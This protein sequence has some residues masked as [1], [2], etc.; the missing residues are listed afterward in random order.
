MRYNIAV[1]HKVS[2][3]H[4]FSK[5]SESESSYSYASNSKE[6][7]EQELFGA[8][9]GINLPYQDEPLVSYPENSDVEEADGAMAEH[10]D[11]DRAEDED[12]IRP[13][14][15][16]KRFEGNIPLLLLSFIY[17]LLDSKI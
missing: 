9:G 8:I 11:E 17:L 5:M 15:F 2:S 6:D 14:Q 4:D 10:A 1:V 12:G 13:L 16:H 3:Y 7:D